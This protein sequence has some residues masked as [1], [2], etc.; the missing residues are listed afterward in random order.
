MYYKTAPTHSELHKTP[1]DVQLSGHY[2]SKRTLKKA[3]QQAS[4]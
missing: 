3:I 2:Q 1:T 4:S